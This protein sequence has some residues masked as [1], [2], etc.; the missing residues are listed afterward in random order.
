MTYR[1]FTFS[2]AFKGDSSESGARFRK[3]VHQ[4]HKLPGNRRESGVTVPGIFI[5]EMVLHQ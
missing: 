1:D 4:V 5:L 3:N 2:A